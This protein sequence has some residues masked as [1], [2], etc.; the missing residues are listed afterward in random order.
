MAPLVKNLDDVAISTITQDGL[1]VGKQVV[2]AP[3]AIGPASTGLAPVTAV[4]PDP[5]VPRN[6]ADVMPA[7]PGGMDALRKFLQ[8]NLQ[9]PEDIAE[10]E[11]VLV[12]IKF[13]VG[14]DGKLQGFDVVKDGGR[15]FNQ[16]VVRVLKKMPE[17][18]P[19]KS[20]GQNVAVYYT[21]P[22]RFMVSD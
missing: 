13:V 4:V 2:Q 5:S 3:V 16:E 21:I 18:I 14:Y 22:V 9:N 20:N 6:T 15:A 7:Y 11:E 1:E 8:K 19:G 10:G 12:K 17:W